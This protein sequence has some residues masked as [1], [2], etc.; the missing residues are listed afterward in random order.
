MESWTCGASLSHS[1]TGKSESVAPR[2]P[3][4]KFIRL[5][6]SF[7]GVDTKVV[8]LDKLEVDVSRFEVRFDYLCGLVIHDV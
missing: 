6:G 7:G 8:G 3:M 2:A 4:K 1:W 5:D